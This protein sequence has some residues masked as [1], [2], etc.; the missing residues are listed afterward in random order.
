MKKTLLL[1]ALCGVTLF[2]C[3]K[4]DDDDTGNQSQKTTLL[5]QQTWKFDNA[6]I[7]I[8]RDG[9]SKYRYRRYHCKPA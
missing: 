2:G 1:L 4:E 9:T 3:D 6:G 5:V 7:D 8:N